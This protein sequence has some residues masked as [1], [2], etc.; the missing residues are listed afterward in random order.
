M[1][2]ALVLSLNLIGIIALKFI[3]GGEVQVSQNFPEQ[4]APGES[5]ILEIQI[6][7]GDQEGFAKWQQ[8]LPKGFIAKPKETAGATFSFKNQDVKLIWMA[9]PQSESI[10]ISYEIS[11]D[12]SLS[13]E[14]ELEGKFSFIEENERKDISSEK[15]KLVIGEASEMLAAS[16]AMDNTDSLEQIAEN[17]TNP[18]SEM[19]TIESEDPIESEEITE[20]ENNEIADLEESSQEI[21]EEVVNQDYVLDSEGIKIKRSLEHLG[22]GMYGVNLQIEKGTT[23]SFGKIEEYLPEDFT[24]EIIESAGGIVTFKNRV[25]KVL[26]MTLPEDELIEVSYMMTSQT[27][28]FDSTEV[29]GVF[30]F[31]K[32]NET[33]QLELEASHFKNYYVAPP[34]ENTAIAEVNSDSTNESSTAEVIAEEIANNET[35]PEAS[36][37]VDENIEEAKESAIAEASESI[38]N[39]VSNVPAPESS[40]SYKV[41]LAAGKKEVEKDYFKKR[42]NV[43]EP[44]AIEFHET[45]YKY[46]VGKHDVYKSARDHRNEYWN[47]EKPVKDAFVTAYNAGERISVQEALMISKQK[48]FK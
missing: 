10:L 44:V 48:W 22:D 21:K 16:E 17:N 24:A 6:E 13:G 23:T 19:D 4:I 39:A 33:A 29:H 11:V 8:K 38:E 46:T 40:I 34:Q 42:F 25:L 14:F 30:S 27:D 2:K 3:F 47:R 1:F 32:N 9:L 5:F 7:K 18:I 28:L 26:W 37:D 36:K 20:E 12:P 41:Q 31:L 15:R 45:W 35:V 43:S